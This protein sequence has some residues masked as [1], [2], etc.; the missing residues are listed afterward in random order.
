MIKLSIVIPCHNEADN[1]AELLQEFSKVI[2]DD[3]ELILV[4]NN[5]TDNTEKVL[6]EM[7]NKYKFFTYINE[8]KQGYGRAILSGLRV[9]SGEFI[10]WTHGDLQ[11]PPADIIKAFDI[12]KQE[13]KSNN[14]YI[15]GNRK[16]RS[17]FDNI[18]TVGMSIFETIFLGKIMWDIN[19]QP[20]I[21]HRSFFNKWINPPIDFSL[22]LYAYYF[23]KKNKNKIIRFPVYFP[24]RKRGESSW[25]HGFTSK[26]KFIKR[27]LLFSFNLKNS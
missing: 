9:A 1:L 10:G 13:G 3:M 25:N 18:F 27:T 21:F 16:R 12:I 6:K 22:D 24:P 26:W 7:I 17:F 20:N 14:L 15:K 11:T 4:N 5:S 8:P 23:A 19:A 2:G